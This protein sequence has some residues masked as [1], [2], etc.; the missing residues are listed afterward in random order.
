MPKI[1]EQVPKYAKKCLLRQLIRKRKGLSL[2]YRIIR[3]RKQYFV[4]E[5]NRITAEPIWIRIVRTYQNRVPLGTRYR[6]A[7]TFLSGTSRGRVRSVYSYRQLCAVRGYCRVPPRHM[8]S[9]RRLHMTRWCAA[10]THLASPRLASPRH[11]SP[12][13]A[14]PRVVAPTFS[15]AQK[16][17]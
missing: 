7:K 12:R 14:P 1:T 10:C 8:Q 2:K 6:F 4:F 17:T 15:V 16:K 9:V 11:G 5:L 13:P 3:F